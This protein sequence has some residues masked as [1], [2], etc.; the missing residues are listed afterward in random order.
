MQFNDAQ[1]L[2]FVQG[3]AFQINRRVYEA[4]YP[5]FDYGRLVYVNS[6]GPEW[7]PGILTYTSGRKGVRYLFECQEANS[8]APKYVQFSDHTIAPRKS[9]HFHIFMGNRSQQDLL[10]EMD[11]WPT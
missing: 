4:R 10:A 7:A 1:T 5:D 6:E 3:Q 2:S 9:A 11:N 8:D